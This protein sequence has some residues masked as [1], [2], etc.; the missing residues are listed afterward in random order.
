METTH[1]FTGKADVY[2]KY[3]PGYPAEYINYLISY[4]N[5]SQ[6][7]IIADIGSG[8]GILTRQLLDKK[9]K[10]IA[11]EPNN[12]MRDVAE[13]ALNGYQNFISIN[14]TAEKTGIRQISVDLITAAQSFHWFDKNK[15]KLECGRISKPNSKVALVWNSRDFSSQFVIDQAEINKR[16]CPLFVGFSGGIEETPQIFER[17]FKD[18]KYDYKCFD[19]NTELD[20]EGF[21]GRNLSASYAPRNTDSNYKK[22]IEALTELFAK[23]NKN[24]TIILHNITRSYIGNV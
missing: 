22:Y 15:F 2:S 13:K 4:N 11:V 8:T 7:S 24:G 14:G 12:E 20:L 21:I 9:L 3:R 6:D 18:V 1:K 5:L 23:Y 10:V 19:H 16:L 17:F